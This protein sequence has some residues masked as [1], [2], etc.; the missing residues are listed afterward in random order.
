MCVHVQTRV[1][2]STINY[3]QLLKCK[4]IKKQSFKISKMFFIG[5]KERSV[6]AGTIW[7]VQS[8]GPIPRPAEG[9]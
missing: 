3:R 9:L 8:D 5:S 7:A 2:L 6:P 1:I 4:A